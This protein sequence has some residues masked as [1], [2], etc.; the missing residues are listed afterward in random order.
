MAGTEGA[1]A[2]GQGA[3]ARHGHAAQVDLRVGAQRQGRVFFD[4]LHHLHRAAVDRT[5]HHRATGGDLAHHADAT[6]GVD[7]YRGATGARGFAQRVQATSGTDDN[8]KAIVV[9]A[10]RSGGLHQHVASGGDGG[11]DQDLLTGAQGHGRVVLGKDQA[12]GGVV[13]TSGHRAMNFHVSRSLQQHIGAAGAAALGKHARSGVHVKAGALQSG[14]PGVAA[15]QVG[16]IGGHTTQERDAARHGGFG[17]PVG[18]GVGLHQ[19]RGVLAHQ[20]DGAT[21]DGGVFDLDVEVCIGLQRGQGAGEQETI[22]A[23]AGQHMWFAHLQRV[24]LA[25]V[26][27]IQCVKA[28]AER[29]VGFIGDHPTVGRQLAAAAPIHVGV[30]IVSA[31]ALNKLL[32]QAVVA[33]IGVV[34]NRTAVSLEAAGGQ[35]LG[36]LGLAQVGKG[37][38]GGRHIDVAPSDAGIGVVGIVASALHKAQAVAAGFGV[39]KHRATPTAV[40]GIGQD[41]VLLLGRQ[42]TKGQAIGWLLHIAPNQG[43]G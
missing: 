15:A 1:A 7:Q 17:F 11:V 36:L 13:S 9:S 19:K 37:G 6:H 40:A 8:A 24:H 2:L 23:L 27:F 34:I 22:A 43:L 35:D 16:A 38:A 26:V 12:V 41:N 5:G 4:P 42:F 14:G 10:G 18:E 25:I 39:E 33:G 30:A 20:V 3:V 29:R 28:E 32:A 31:L 21:Q